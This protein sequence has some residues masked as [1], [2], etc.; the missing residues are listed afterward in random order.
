MKKSIISF[1]LGVILTFSVMTYINTQAEPV[2]APTPTPQIVYVTPTPMPTPT[3]Q[4]IYKERLTDLETVVENVKDSCVM[5]YAYMPNGRVEQSSGWIYNGNI[6]TVKH[7]IEGANKVDIF[8]DNLFGSVRGTIHY[9]DDNLDVAVLS[10]ERKNTVSVTLGDNEKLIEGEKLVSITSPQ[11]AQNMIDECVYS[12]KLV[13]KTENLISISEAEI[14]PGS[15][16]GAIYNYQSEIIGMTVS[17]GG[18]YAAAIPIN[19]I[20]PVLEKLK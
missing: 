2:Q 12:G 3:P 5:I 13:T 19:H 9:L 8:F 14:E 16:G 17:G 10:Y 20:K 4:I 15:S 1:L 11:G 6:I 18:G 7:G